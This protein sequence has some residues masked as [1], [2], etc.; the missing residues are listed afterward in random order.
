MQNSLPNQ[1]WNN[2]VW[3]KDRYSQFTVSP[4]CFFL[5]FGQYKELIFT[6][7]WIFLSPKYPKEILQK[8]QKTIILKTIFFERK[9]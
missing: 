1:H 4:L 9:K 3:S 8:T 6:I 5:P 2:G 7:F